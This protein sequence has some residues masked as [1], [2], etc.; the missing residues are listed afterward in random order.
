MKIEPLSEQDQ[1][2]VEDM[3]RHMYGKPGQ[4]FALAMALH[5][6]T[7][8]PLIGVHRGKDPIHELYGQDADGNIYTPNGVVQKLELAPDEEIL[9]ITIRNQIP[10]L[11]G[12]T[13]P[14]AIEWAAH[15]AQAVWPHLNWTEDSRQGRVKAFVAGL[16][17]LCKQHGVSLRGPTP[18]WMFL[19]V[20]HGDESF[21]LQLHVITTGGEYILTTDIT[22]GKG[23][24]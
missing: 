15:A 21:K 19:G 6:F 5:N 7:R 20:W 24:A 3:L 22:P 14:A 10:K 17:A 4:S 8:M 18:G 11:S 1:R 23:E 12:T 16:A 13:D 2:S 9:R